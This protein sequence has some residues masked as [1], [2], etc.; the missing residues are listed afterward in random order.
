VLVPNHRPPSREGQVF[1][2]NTEPLI[3]AVSA[4]L[5]EQDL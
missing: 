3:E 2:D 4:W 5:A 1:T